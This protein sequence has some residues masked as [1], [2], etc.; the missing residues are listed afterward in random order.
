M[1]SKRFLPSCAF[2]TLPGKSPGTIK[3]QE[4]SCRIAQK[5]E[6]CEL[7]QACMNANSNTK[8]LTP[9]QFCQN[10]PTIKIDQAVRFREAFLQATPDCTN[11]FIT[12]NT[13][14][15]SSEKIEDIENIIERLNRLKSNQL[16]QEKQKITGQ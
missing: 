2:E 7:F 15:K 3:S 11:P 9:A 16:E 8:D 4:F 1:E 5:G 6:P 14:I 10:N 12:Y 13:I